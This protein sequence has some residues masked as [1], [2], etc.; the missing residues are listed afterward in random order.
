MKNMTTGRPMKLIAGFAVPL[1]IGS[2]F[3]QIYNFV[4][5]I[6]VGRYLGEQA[7]AG[8]GSTGNLTFFLLALVMGL[9]NGAGIIVAQCVGAEDYARMRR[10]VTA[11]IWIAGILTAAV[12]VIGVCA[13]RF[14]LILLSV[15]EDVIGYSEQYLRIVYFFVAGSVAYNGCSA[16]LRSFGDSKTPLYG[17]IAG[18]VLNIVLD[19]LL[20]LG[21]GMGVAGVAAATVVSQ[22]V[23]AAYC[24]VYLFIKRGRFNLSGLKLMPD[25]A[26]VGL[27]FKTGV[28]TAFQSCLI[29]LGGMSV[30]RLINSF[31]ASVMA[32][33]AAAG[34][35]DSI[36]IQVIVSLGTALSVFT[37]QNIGQKRFDRIKA[38]LRDTLFMSVTAGIVIACIAFFFGRNLMML[39]LGEGESPEAVHIGAEYLAIMGAAYLICGIMQSYQNII[40]GAG[41]VNTCMIAGMTELAGRIFFAYLLAPRIGV[42]GIWIATPLSWGCGCIVPVIRY[43]TGRWKTKA[44]IPSA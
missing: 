43:Y 10:A 7:L 12:A 40:R 11:I 2:I 1:L 21:A 24:L 42:T 6:I 35:I 23:S 8:V 9:C 14:F 30:Q 5:V 27:I 37:G 4:D 25:K 15:P 36:A 34:R 19:L 3:Q 22:H 41:D 28:P 31:G 38:G 16:I 13:S 39:F 26:M 33:Y 17:L 29:S 20:V 18:S 32:A 44:V